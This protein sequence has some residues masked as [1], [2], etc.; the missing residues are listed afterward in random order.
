MTPKAGLAGALVVLAAGVVAV[1]TKDSSSSKASRTVVTITTLAPTSTTTT[2]SST[3]TIVSAPPPTTTVTV[4]AAVPTPEAAAN[5]LWAAYAADNETAA[6]RFASQDVIAALFATPFSGEAG[7]FESCRQKR[8]GLFDCGYGQP[9]THYTM[10]AEADDGRSFRIVVI[11]IE[12]TGPTSTDSF[13][14]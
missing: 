8:E 2:S 3:S 7:Q 12:S 9:S 14:G 4:R 1:A 11:V 13:S 6:A 5:G 10:T